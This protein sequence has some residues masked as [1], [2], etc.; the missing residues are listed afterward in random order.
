M[1]NLIDVIQQA[2][3]FDPLHRI[4]GSS[5]QTENNELVKQGLI[6]QAVIPS[7]LAGFYKYTRD[8]KNAEKIIGGTASNW[9]R[10]LFGDSLNEISQRI[11]VYAGISAQEADIE[12]KCIADLVAENIRNNVPGKTGSGVREYITDQRKHILEY[13]PPVL[14]LD[15]LL[16]EEKVMQN[17]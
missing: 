5:E 7:V 1:T 14:Q 10:I 11:S 6:G 15:H 13:L 17:V 2:A 9:S 3:G 16:K 4:D 8:E 12:I